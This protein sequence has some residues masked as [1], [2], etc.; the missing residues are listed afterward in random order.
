MSS[1]RTAG[2]SMLGSNRSWSVGQPVR[3][4]DD[5][6]APWLSGVVVG[7]ASSGPVVQARGGSA[8]SLPSSLNAHEWRCVEQCEG[9]GEVSRDALLFVAKDSARLSQWCASQERAEMLAGVRRH[10]W[11]HWLWPAARDLPPDWLQGNGTAAEAEELVTSGGASPNAAAAMAEIE[12]DIPR[13][14]PHHPEAADIRVKTKEVLG[15]YCVL[16]NPEVGYCQGMNYVAALLTRVVSPDEAVC[17]L[18]HFVESVVPDYYR[19]LHGVVADLEV[20]CWMLEEVDR[21]LAEHLLLI[22]FNAAAAFTQTLVCL[23]ALTLPAETALLL[24][25]SVLSSPHPRSHLLRLCLALALGAREALLAAETMQQAH[26]D[27]VLHMAGVYGAAELEQAAQRAEALV[28]EERIQRKRAEVIDRFTGLLEP[29]AL[30]DS[31]DGGSESERQMSTGVALGRRQWVQDSAA[32]N[33]ALCERAFTLARRRHHCRHCGEV[34]C[35]DCSRRRAPLERDGRT[36]E[37]R[38]C[39]PCF[40]AAQ[41]QHRRVSPVPS[42]SHSPVSSQVL[43]AMA[44]AAANAAFDTHPRAPS[45]ARWTEDEARPQ[46]VVCDTPFSFARRRHHCRMC[47]EVVCGGC[48]RDREVICGQP[49]ARPVR[50]C[51]LCRERPA[52]PPPAAQRSDAHGRRQSTAPTGGA[53]SR[54]G[55]PPSAPPQGGGGPAAAADAAPQE[56]PPVPAEPRWSPTFA[57]KAERAAAAAPDSTEE[58][59]PAARQQTETD[60]VPVES[61]PRAAVSAGSSPPTSPRGKW[62]WPRP[63][64]SP[65]AAPAPSPEPVPPDSPKPAT[66]RSPRIEVTP[67]AT[68]LA[69]SQRHWVSDSAA[70]TCVRCRRAFTVIRRK[71]HCRHCGEVV[72]DACSKAREPLEL[73]GVVTAMRVCSAC[74]EQFDSDRR[75]PLYRLL[76]PQL[77]PHYFYPIATACGGDVDALLRLSPQGLT[78]L[79]ARAGVAADQQATV[80]SIIRKVQHSGAYDLSAPPGKV[81]RSRDIPI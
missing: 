59:R 13:T 39:D 45:G 78:D 12:K 22:N 14:W 7:F 68:G 8:E 37:H 60:E 1:H 15:R 76:G 11:L 40:G 26:D 25:R 29:A 81:Q 69:V 46:C 44:V 66:V 55:T 41:K 75:H 32:A 65:E 61:S 73:D 63:P 16:R 56:G 24:W 67:T 33:C 10:G 36:R 23:F 57:A 47:G 79:V 71:H 34:I 64:R 19:G 38:V 72:C 28:S 3:V 6:A 30:V 42:P 51:V 50:V 62:T 54:S 80:C 21:G 58:P 74:A 70:P 9:E 17:M 35:D 2:S 27:L 5:A 77:G 4:R 52:S 53:G 20:L 31:D 18:R 48:S 49:E 43:P